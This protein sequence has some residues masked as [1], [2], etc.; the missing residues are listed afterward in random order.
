MWG[1]DMKIEVLGTGCAKCKRLEENVR[2]ALK[3]AKI[4][5]EVL[6]VEDLQEII[7]RGIMLTPALIIDGDAKAVGRIPSVEEIKKMIT[8]GK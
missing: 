7:D 8:G 4:Q 3:E 1:D 5:A 2:K 6:K